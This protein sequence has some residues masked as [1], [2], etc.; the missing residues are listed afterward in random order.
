M[1]EDIREQLSAFMDGELGRE[2]RAFL[3]RRL[4]HD[5]NLRGTWARYHLIRDVLAQRGS[6]RPLDLSAS[7][8]AAIERDEA[9]AASARTAPLWRPWAGLA[10]AASVALLALGVLSPRVERPQAAP[11]E[12]VAVRAAPAVDLPRPIVPSIPPGAAGVQP[13]SADRTAILVSDPRPLRPEELMLLRHGQ[14]AQ[15][16]WIVGGDEY[17]YGWPA[18]R[19]QPAV[20][21]TAY[22]SP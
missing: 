7:V 10:V 22:P 19:A 8:M 6:V 5:A 15:P 9:A 12:V 2:E 18:A 4:D 11:G 21:T 1:S 16:G 20:Q 17:V 14:L 13:V 3:L